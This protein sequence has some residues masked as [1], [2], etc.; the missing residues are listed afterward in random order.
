MQL[1]EI[2]LLRM[3]MH[4]KKRKERAEHF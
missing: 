4:R 3:F 1:N 2:G